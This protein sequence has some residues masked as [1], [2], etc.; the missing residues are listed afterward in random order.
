MSFENMWC[1][2][3]GALGYLVESRVDLFGDGLF[4]SV[5][6]V[7]IASWNEVGS[8]VKEGDEIS[9]EVVGCEIVNLA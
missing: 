9:R 7:V 6:V 1:R 5:N 2:R 8:F 4:D 3:V